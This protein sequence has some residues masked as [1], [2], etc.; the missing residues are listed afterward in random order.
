MDA[1]AQQ[2]AVPTG[3]TLAI[4]KF[5][6]GSITCLRFQGTIDEAFDGKRLAASI[7][8]S[9]LILDMGAVKKI[10]SFGIREWTD[11]IKAVERQV[12]QL[13]AIECTPKVVD[14]INM[15][16]QFLGTKGQV[17]S[18]YAPYRCD[19]CDIDRRVL[20][21]IDRDQAAIRGLRPPEQ[22][23]ETC[24]RPEYFDEEPGAFFSY[25]ATQ[26]PFELSPEIV[27]FLSSKLRYALAGGDRRLH[28][29]KQIEGRSTYLKFVGN[30]DGSLP[31]TKI[32]EGLEGVIVVDL[33]GVGTVDLAG[34]AEWRNFITMTK[35][36]A[37][38][39]YLVGVPPVMLQRLTRPGDLG[40][41]LVSFTMPYSCAKCATTGSQLIEVAEHYDILKFATPPEMKCTQCKSSTVCVAPEALLSRL[42]ALPNVEI[43]SP[44]RKFIKEMRERKPERP[45]P[46]KKATA[47]GS[48]LG[49]FATIMVIAVVAAG[50]LVVINWYQQRETLSQLER[51]TSEAKPSAPV[52]PRPAWITS[53]TP[54]SSYC[55]AYADK[56]ACVGVSSY[57]VSRDAAR[58]EAINGALEEMANTIGLKIPVKGFEEVVRPL[59]GS[60]RAD[61]LRALDTARSAPASDGY[62]RAL[63]VVRTA[64]QAAAEAL[65]LTGGSAA[66]VQQA[67]WYWEEYKRSDATGTEFLVFVRFDLNAEG[68]RSLMD[69][70]SVPV[71]VAGTKVVTMFPGLVWRTPD[72]KQGVV[73]LEVGGRLKS[74]GLEN[75]DLV[76]A[77]NGQPVR[78]SRDFAARLEKDDRSLVLTVR[79]KDG[80]ARE[81]RR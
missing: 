59:F 39:V 25:V 54:L 60:V 66:P 46:L 20:F 37:E 41:H 61:A 57:L 35:S 49:M 13:I 70:Y 67:D 12:Q 28:V 9:T 26:Q 64:R 43:D 75:R 17:F 48:R 72:V 7:K 31:S 65:P 24:S 47:A 62:K 56:L 77:V 23:C 58:L 5:I 52:A 27:E 16:S 42:R 79:G 1:A 14:Q 18:F 73:A 71:E 53:D 76:T 34:A 44:L 55:T 69:E 40:D 33:S 32:A 51:V 38:R 63:E 80:K 74:L 45:Q 29:D 3:A 2:A 68:L 78:N 6:E 21:Q 4:D 15:V 50:S 22:L 10:S 11:F 36:T 30:L 19:Y 81:L 8:C